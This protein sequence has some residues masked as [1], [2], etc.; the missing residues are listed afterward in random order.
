MEKANEAKRLQRKQKRLCASMRE[1][2]EHAK[3]QQW[4]EMLAIFESYP[5]L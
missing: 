3:W 4:D 2:I 1:A 5:G